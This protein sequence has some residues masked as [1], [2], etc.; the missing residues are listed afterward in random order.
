MQWLKKLI[1]RLGPVGRFIRSAYYTMPLQMFI[2][3]L[4]NNKSV[5]IIWVFLFGVST[6][7]ILNSYGGA[8]LLLEPEYQDKFDFWS[9]F[10][11]GVGVGIYTMSF[12]MTMYILDGHKFFFL[13]FEKRP[14]IKFCVNN[15]LIPLSFFIL[16]CFLFF[17]L[18][19]SASLL[20]TGQILSLLS[21]MFIG[22]AVTTTLTLSYFALTNKDIF[23]IVGKK[24]SQEIRPQRR[25]I[26]EAR[27]SLGVTQRVDYFFTMTL[28]LRPV[29][30]DIHGDF[31][32]MVR[33]M[34][35]NHTNALVAMLILLVSL[36]T[37][38]FFQDEP[39]AQP[40]AGVS[41]LI[42]FSLILMVV[43]AL[44]FWLRKIGILAFIAAVG[45]LIVLENWEPF[46]GR[47]YAYGIDYTA[48]PVPYN[49]GHFATLTPPD[50]VRKDSLETVGV[51]N[52]WLAKQRTV[53]G[54][55]RKPKMLFVLSS[56]GGTRSAYWTSYCVQKTDSLLAGRLWPQTAF[57]TG[58]SGGM[59]AMAYLRELYWEKQT[60]NPQLN[61]YSQQYR[62]RVS[63]DLLNPI[64]FNVAV[65]FFF[66][67]KEFEDNGNTYDADR[68]YAF[69]RQ[70]VR[71]TYRFNERRLGDYRNAELNAT[72]P[73]MM[74]SPAVIND[75]RQLMI[76]PLGVSYM[77]LTKRFNSAYKSPLTALDFR[78][79]FTNHDPDSLLYTSAL[80]MNASFPYVLP[81]PELPTEPATQ[82]MDA[83][84]YD[85]YGIFTSLRFVHFFR[86]W[87]ERNTSGVVLLAIRDSE[88]DGEIE[89]TSSGS[90]FARLI[91][92][93]G[94]TLHSSFKKA[95]YINDQ[96]LEYLS[97]SMAVPVEY[98]EYQYIP[99][100]KFEGASLTFHLTEV[101]RKRIRESF[102]RTENQQTVKTL[103]QLLFPG[104]PELDLSKLVPG[105][106]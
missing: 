39:W 47:Y 94:G 86:D 20:T 12:N 28:K 27:R 52:N 74:L 103:H 25:I 59:L 93:L 62:R 85:N 36:G 87:I 100:K 17:D 37:L 83:G 71:N 40:P 33:V 96:A 95:D 31:R 72:I 68:G 16:Y 90:I 13:A 75:G 3:Q 76:S 2:E 1:D 29:P 35:Q 77:G 78:R 79:L 18:H 81:F 57:I 91:T 55:P 73:M 99:T 104:E 84:I 80:R 105:A 54:N 32:Y 45:L 98:L 6:R 88:T 44:S 8:N 89:P 97:E 34:N 15:S 101:E 63:R 69:E 5:L 49:H 60:I 56:G 64:I 22:W 11:L 106:E 92:S 41:F 42:L 21:A 10:I 30:E 7:V 82:V 14:F 24:V 50:T 4:R 26:R 46:S 38:W 53:P 66:P 65:N 67:T 19:A 70:F 48:A 102:Y 23:K 43:G 9:M 61:L 58:A 51:L